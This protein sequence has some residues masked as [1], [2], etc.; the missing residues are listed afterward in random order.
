MA[1]RRFPIAIPLVLSL[2]C[3]SASGQL[4]V[5]RVLSLSR[6]G[7]QLSTEFDLSV[8]SGNDLEEVDQLQFSHPSIAAQALTDPPRPFTDEPRTRYRHF[9]VRLPADLPPGRYEVRASGRFG[10]SNP[11]SFIITALPFVVAEPAHANQSQAYDLPRDTFVQSKANASGM[12]YYRMELTSGQTVEADCLAERIDSPC[13]PAISLLSAAGRE[14]A[15][16]IGTDTRDPTLRYTAE[17]GGTYFLAVHDLLFRGG[18]EFAYQLLAVDPAALA[19][20]VVVALKQV[21][22][23][24]SPSS[25]SGALGS[26]P[27]SAIGSATYL[28]TSDIVSELPEDEQKGTS[29]QKLSSIPCIVKGEFSG[30]GDEDRYDFE[31]A[32]GDRL[33]IEVI[34]D[35]LNGLTDPVVRRY[36]KS[37]PP[38]RAR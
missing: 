5:T 3:V 37:Y 15:R 23:Q 22:Y 13:I 9:H 30:A 25:S 14:L 32:A 27:V 36:R 29:P 33:M 38:D 26:L 20:P 17:Q 6:A 19:D 18:D 10:L 34:S 2:L 16:E 28:A 4:P 31:V 35:R 1:V 8:V 24:G 21:R 11:R 7:G 12:E